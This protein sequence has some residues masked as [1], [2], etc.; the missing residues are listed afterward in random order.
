MFI[1]HVFKTIT[2]KTESKTLAKDTSWK[3]KCK[4]DKR[5]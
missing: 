5:K 2:E 3:C 1:I 4:F